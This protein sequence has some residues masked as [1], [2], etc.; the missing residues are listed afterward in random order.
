MRQDWITN[1]DKTTAVLV[2]TR[3]LANTLNEQVAEFYIEQGRTVWEAPNIVI[4][5]DYIKQLWALNKPM[6]T[7][8]YGAKHLISAQQSLLLW[9]QIIESTKREEQ[10]LTLLN[11]QQTARAVQRSWILMHD[12][13]IDIETIEQD[14]DADSVQFVSWLKAYQDL[15]NKRGLFDE[16]LLLNALC[17]EKNELDFPYKQLI[18]YAF[19]LINATQ[20]TINQRAQSNV[21]IQQLLPP[22]LQSKR[23]YLS[24]PDTQSEL[25]ACF[26]TARKLIE[27][28]P[29]CSINIV[30]HDLQDRQAQVDELARQVFYPGVS[31]IDVQQSSTVFRYSLGQRLTQWAAIDTAL[32]VINLLKNHTTST[33]LSFLLRNQF[34]GLCS[35]HRQECRVFDRWLKRQRLRNITLEQ[36]PDLYQQC[37]S[38]LEEQGQAIE[39]TGFMQALEMLVHRYHDLRERLEQAKRNNQFLALSFTEWVHEFSEWLEIWGWSTKTVGNELNTVQH[40]LLKRW[41]SLFQEFAGLA[42]VQ[43]RAGLSRAIDLVTQMARDAMFIPKAAASPI[44]ISS[45]L[46]AVGRPADYCFVLG[47]NESFPPAPKNDAFI[48]QRLLASAGHPDMSADSSFAQAQTVI[49]NLL[50]SVGDS[51]I[52][53]AQQNDQDREISQQCSPLFRHQAFSE[54]PRLSKTLPSDNLS[55]QLERYQD[56][57]G[58]PWQASIRASG[59][60]KVFENQSHCPFKAFVTHQLTFQAEQEAEFGL[61]FLDR[62]NVVHLLLDRIWQQLQTQQQLKLIDPSALNALIHQVIDQ[63]LEDTQLELSE[64]KRRL[65]SYERPRLVTLLSEWLDFEAKR[66]EPFMVIEREEKRQGE[67]G[68][69]EFSYIIDRLDMT[70]DRRSLS[71]DHKTDSLNKKNSSV[72]PL[73]YP[74]LPLV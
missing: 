15:L 18:F 54:Q 50:N 38:S 29:D 26:Q 12:W 30:I 67:L 37:L 28:E 71:I 39:L 17:D 24:Y 4:W 16:P 72:S 8:H 55:N 52:S 51:V 2:P 59:G 3:S 42:A 22:T 33:E 21:K 73:H 58:S 64:D 45:I 47:M 7:Q 60:S 25:I 65:L 46:E 27:S 48:A 32:S 62:G 41:E 13:R 10:A 69:I 49:T 70:E 34:L 11:V 19:D 68:G 1:L 53:F 61:D 44:L 6:L 66:P 23:Q 57:Q 35:Q 20:E 63:T 14:H 40:Q 31:P 74:P 43:R 36:L 56:Q 9:T 5:R